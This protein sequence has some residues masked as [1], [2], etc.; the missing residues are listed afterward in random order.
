MKT[1]ETS[2]LQR[3][4][5]GEAETMLA[6]FVALAGD[7]DFW[8]HSRDG[9]AVLGGKDTFQV[10]KLQRPVAEL[11]VVADTFHMKP[12]LRLRQSADRYQVLG[13]SRLHMRLFEGNQ[14][15]L[16]EIEPN[17]LVPRTM[18]DALGELVT[19]SQQTV[20]SYGGV[21]GSH[22]GM[23]HGHIDKVEEKDLDAERF[24]RAVDR[25]VTEHHSKPS[26][27]PLILA[28]LPAHRRMFHELSHNMLLVAQDID[29]NPDAISLDELRERAWQVIEPLYV[30]QLDVTIEEFGSA[31]AREM[32]NDDL[33]A[34]AA[35]VVAGRVATL[36]VEAERVIP[37]RIN[38]ETGEV[39]LADLSLPDVDDL[40]DDLTEMAAKMGGKVVVV[41]A[42]RMPTT[43]GIAA[44][45]RY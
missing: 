22:T 35:A 45:Y 4:S 43:T 16:D 13:I 8:T 15:G 1:L 39:M 26:G 17:A 32:G 25:A 37:G 27:L 11:A 30:A 10:F 6:P 38:A 23:H 9:L 41:P 3:V 31:R 19:E 24:F 36:M 5:A 29:V 20:G 7:H 14:Y 42:D 18:T 40:L 12:L 21:G 33:S 2:L 28:T 44:S 34:V